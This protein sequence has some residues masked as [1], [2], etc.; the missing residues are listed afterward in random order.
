MALVI[1]FD[2][3]DRHSDKCVE[4]IA[5]VNDADFQFYWS[6]QCNHRDFYFVRREIETNWRIDA[7][8][9]FSEVDARLIQVALRIAAAPSPH[10]REEPVA[11]WCE[12]DGHIDTTIYI[13]TAQ[14]WETDFKRKVIPLVFAAPPPARAD[15][16]R[17][18]DIVRILA[19]TPPNEW[20]RRSEIYAEL[21][22]FRTLPAPQPQEKPE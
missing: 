19:N 16:V 8:Q 7:D 20:R 12:F 9:K 21:A 1:V 22:E 10:P 6:K 13:D 14:R 11:W 5:D 15:A 18:L 17:A 4:R 3:F 2:I